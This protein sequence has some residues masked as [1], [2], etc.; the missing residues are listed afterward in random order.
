MAYRVMLRLVGLWNLLVFGVFTL[1]F[2]VLVAPAQLVALPFDRERRVAATLTRWL[3][4]G[5]MITAHQPF[6]RV[7]TTGLER[8]GK[9][10]WIVAC[11]H[12]SMLDI[13]LASRLPVPLR[14]LAR[15]GVFRMPVFGLMAQHG[16][17]INLDPSSPAALEAALA[18]ARRERDAGASIL[19]FP[20]GTRGDGP[21]LLPFKRGMFEFAIQTGTDILPVA[22]SGT[23]DALPK[24]SPF[25]RRV[26]ARFHLQVLDPV[27]VAGQSR[28]QLARIVE[29]RLSEA[30]AGPRP[31]EVCAAVKQR[32]EAL[33]RPKAGWAWGKTT[34]DPVFWA[35]H[36]RMPT[37]GRWL[38]VGCGEGLL[39]AYLTAA[40]HALDAHGIDPDAARVGQARALLGDGFAEGDARTLR[41]APA[42]GW[43]VITCIDVLH[44]LTP[45]EQA[46]VVRG[47]ARSLA[48]GGRLLLRDPD[49][50]RGVRGALTVGAERAL[51]AGGRHRGEG[52]RASGASGL[53]ELLRAEF[54]DIRVEDCSAGT[55]FA[56]VLLSARKAGFGVT[57]GASPG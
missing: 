54:E 36:E 6:W 20:E 19:L 50:A 32:Y 40:G 43:D 51:V 27:P 1:V 10:P 47:F 37:S 7:T 41:G 52:V 2:L 17:H 53:A 9:G 12:Q 21:G 33:G 39:A 55:P 24:G 31:W 29:D 18:H 35:L 14:I 22:I 38:D 28:R 48:P 44:Y 45:A 30:L 4:G 15:P 49:A 46:D 3:W 34:F 23:A 5:W 16:R 26:V 57:D 11:N 8:V 56:N 25:A 42:G 13:P